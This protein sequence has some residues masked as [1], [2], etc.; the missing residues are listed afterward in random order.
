MGGFHPTCREREKDDK[1]KK[2][3]FDRE[4]CRAELQKITDH[5]KSYRGLDFP[6]AVEDI[7][8]MIRSYQDNMAKLATRTCLKVLSKAPTDF[9]D[10]TD[11]ESTYNK[12]QREKYKR[13][14]ESSKYS[15]S[16]QS[17]REKEEPSSKKRKH[18][19]ASTDS[20]VDDPC[21]TCGH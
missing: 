5:L 15:T 17:I 14:R 7:I 11:S 3:K 10:K 4:Y 9:N 18:D 1:D 2:P 6:Q 16:K 12:A 8:G 20:K 19:N 13:D 21:N